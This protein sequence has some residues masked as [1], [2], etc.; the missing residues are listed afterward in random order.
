LKPQRRFW[1][2]SDPAF[3]LDLIMTLKEGRCPFNRAVAAYAMQMLKTRRTIRALEETA[4]NKSEHSRVSGEAAEALARGHRRKSHEILLKGLKDPSKDVRFWCA[5][6]LGEMTEKRAIP[7]LEHLLATDGRIVT[8]FH[9]V[10]REAEDATQK[11]SE[12]ESFSQKKVGLRVLHSRL[13]E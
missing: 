9:S 1:D 8:G 12:Q 10:A 4:M 6:A 2:D 7:T 5:I 11:H 3:E 13:V